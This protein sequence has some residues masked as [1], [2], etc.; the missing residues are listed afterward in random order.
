MN[1]DSIRMSQGADLRLLHAA[2]SGRS[3]EEALPSTFPDK[4]LL[5]LAR[6]FRDAEAPYDHR[7]ADI[8]IASP[9][10]A[11][12]TLL[13]SHPDRIDAKKA[14]PKMSEETT[15]NALDAYQYAF[16][17]EIVSR[18]VG[19]GTKQDSIF[20]RTALRDAAVGNA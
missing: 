11:V 4:L 15:Q 7:K 20:L 10:L 13:K 6:D 12:I 3:W 1:L 17:R 18:I 2:I 14:L 9:L 5:E 16:E 19:I 8:D